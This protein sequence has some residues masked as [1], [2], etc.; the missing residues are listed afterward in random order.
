MLAESPDPGGSP[1]LGS[2]GSL[3]ARGAQVARPPL[4]PAGMSGIIP[5]AGQCAAR[6]PALARNIATLPGLH[7]LTLPP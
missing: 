2:P 6:P 7:Y 3:A 4:H 5:A 1:V